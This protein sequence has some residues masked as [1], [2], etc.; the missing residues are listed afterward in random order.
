MIENEITLEKEVAER[1]KINLLKEDSIT[2][3]RRRKKRNKLDSLIGMK[4]G[5]N[6]N[7]GVR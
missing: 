2:M 7:S 4:R 1:K 6:R 3:V 5:K